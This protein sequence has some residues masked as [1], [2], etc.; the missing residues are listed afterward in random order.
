[1]GRVRPLGLWEAEAAVPRG[2]AYVLR[3]GAAA[4]LWTMGARETP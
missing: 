1:M 3:H 4:A 2:R